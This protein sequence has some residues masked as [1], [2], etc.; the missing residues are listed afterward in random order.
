MADVEEDRNQALLVV[1]SSTMS[2][3]ELRRRIPLESDHGW[4]KGSPRPG[5][6]A[7]VEQFS[8]LR[9]ES[10]LEPADPPAH[11]LHDLLDRLQPAQDDVRAVADELARHGDG[12]G[13]LRVW[14]HV[15]G[16]TRDATSVEVGNAQLQAAAALGAEV[17]VTLDCLLADVAA[18]VRPAGAELLPSRGTSPAGIREERLEDLLRDVAP[19]SRPPG[20]PLATDNP[21]R[22]HL[23]IHAPPGDEATV[24][25]TRDEIRSL[26]GLHADLTI[27]AD[28]PGAA[29][30]DE[31]RSPDG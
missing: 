6:S 27:T 18:D 14:V 7:T 3:D 21:I 1:L 15:V 17:Y 12:A 13:S 29:K 9:F 20:E 19:A 5:R 2:L 31:A 10:R 26:V 24:G 22:V 16:V 8:G 28:F 30:A 23:H 25:I 4:A 11:H